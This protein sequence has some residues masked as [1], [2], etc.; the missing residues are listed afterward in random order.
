MILDVTTM[1]NAI[2]IHFT[3][4]YVFFCNIVHNFAMASTPSSSYQVSN[5]QFQNVDLCWCVDRRGIH[6]LQRAYGG[7]LREQRSPRGIESLPRPT[8]QDREQDN[9]YRSSMYHSGCE[10]IVINDM[11]D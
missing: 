1:L 3:W 10:D 9:S 11:E 8:K 4:F 6:Y 7:G 2:K 5:E